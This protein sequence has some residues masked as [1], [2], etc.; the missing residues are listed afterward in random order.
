VT[1]TTGT[2]TT[3][4]IIISNPA[5]ASGTT[6]I[7]LTG[8]QILLDQPVTTPA[9]GATLTVSGGTKAAPLWGS[10]DTAPINLPSAPLGVGAFNG[11]AYY[12]LG[13]DGIGFSDA[14]LPC[15]ITNATQ[16]LVPDNGLAVTA[17]G[18]LKGY[19]TTLGFVVRGLAAFQSDVDILQITGDP[20][21]A[22]LT[23]TDLSC[24][25]G[26]H[27][28]LTLASTTKG[29]L[30]VSPQGLRLMSLSG[31]ISDPIG[32]DGS[33][34]VGP[35][36]DVT[37]PPLAGTAPASRMAAAANGRTYIVG[38]PKTD[39]TTAC[40]WYDMIRGGWTGPHSCAVSMIRTWTSSFVAIPT[41]TGQTTT[42]FRLDDTPV[43]DSTYVEFGDQLTWEWEPSL[44]PDTGQMSENCIIESSIMVALPPG[45]QV[46]I[47]FLNEVGQNLD[48]VAVAG[49]VIPQAYWGDGTWGNDIWGGT[50][51]GPDQGTIRQRQIPWT[52][53]LVFKQGTVNIR[54]LS[55]SGIVLGNLYLR[56]QVQGYLL[57]VQQFPV[58]LGG[59]A[60]LL[61]NDGITILRNNTA[62]NLRPD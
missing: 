22:N 38:V 55:S 6:G 15:Q 59:G 51:L 8:T 62:V 39:G 43:G 60:F 31:E 25:T 50:W 30:F 32:Q 23:L 52:T 33:G 28:P 34:I 9:L 17:I 46:Q 2:L 47:D 26:T 61:A 56:Y 12:A 20:T 57:E 13:E 49:Y 10:G 44:M 3:K 45:E 19:S 37:N 29:L 16:F 41:A 24:A 4:F 58:A 48:G 7:T 18:E 5:T 53:P 27:A 54:G 42:L 11:R 21:T 36:L 14:L 1:G 40:Y 35:F